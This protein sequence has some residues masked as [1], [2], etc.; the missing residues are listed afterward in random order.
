MV[1]YSEA[2]TLQDSC[3]KNVSLKHSPITRGARRH[4]SGVIA[5]LRFPTPKIAPACSD[6]EKNRTVS[7]EIRD[8]ANES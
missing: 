8:I 7:V 1:N 3:A 6:Y 4:R 5:A 2:A